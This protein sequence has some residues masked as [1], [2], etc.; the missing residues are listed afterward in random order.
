M[1]AWQG[2]GTGWICARLGIALLVSGTDVL[3]AFAQSCG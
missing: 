3:A 1:V 2:L